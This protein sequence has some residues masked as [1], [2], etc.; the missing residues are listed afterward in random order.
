MLQEKYRK[1]KEP[2]KKIKGMGYAHNLRIRF[3]EGINI[4]A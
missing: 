3:S 2:K 4:Q 1:K